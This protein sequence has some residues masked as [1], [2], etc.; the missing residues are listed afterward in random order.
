MSVSRKLKGRAE[1]G[2]SAQKPALKV[3]RFAQALKHDDLSSLLGFHVRLAHVAIYRDFMEEMAPLGL[4]QK[5]GAVLILIGANPGTSQVTLAK[6]LGTDRAT[7]MAMVNRL[8]A[9]KLIERRASESDRRRWA[10]FPTRAGKAVLEDMKRR[11]AG[12]ENKFA[13]RFTDQELAQF[14]EFL[15]RVHKK[16]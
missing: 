15:S 14:M 13:S 6:F 3:S 8:Q 1:T 5:Q 16:L 9:G 4:T 12:H 10:L 7:M 2:P 11:I